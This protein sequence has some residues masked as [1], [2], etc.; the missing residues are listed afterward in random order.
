MYLKGVSLMRRPSVKKWLARRH[1]FLKKPL[2]ILVVLSAVLSLTAVLFAYLTKVTLDSVAARDG[3]RFVMGAV[4]LV[5]VLLAQILFKSLH[6]YLSVY[7]RTRTDNVL[8]RRFYQGFL[9][10]RHQM[11]ADYHTGSLMNTLE[12]DVGTV[13]EGLVMLLPEAVFLTL[14]F[15]LAFA[16]LF[17]L[18]WIFGA[19]MFGIGGLFLLASFLIRQA[20]KRRHNR[21]KDVEGARRGY[22]QETLAHS[23][24]IKAF[25]AE[26]YSTDR[27]D[28]HQSEFLKATMRKHR[29]TLFAAMALNAFFAGGY[30][31]AIIYGGLRM[32]EGVLMVGSLVAIIQLIQYMQS[33]FSGLSSLMPK[34][35]SL[36]ASAE[37]LM[38]MENLPK[39]PD[40]EDEPEGPFRGVEC[41]N[42]HFKYEDAWIIAGLDLVI[43]AGSFI[44]IEGASGIGKTTF[45]KLLLGLLEPDAGS[46]RFNVG[47]RPHPAGMNTRPLLTYVPQTPM[48]L[49]GTIRENIVFNTEGVTPES[50]REA[51]RIAAIDETI[52]ALEEGYDTR[53]NEHGK[54]FSEGQLQRLAIA[55]AVLRDAPVLLLDEVTSALDASSEAL[56]LDNLKQL[57]D[58][59]CLVISHRPIPESLIDRRLKL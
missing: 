26:R 12:S 19:L 45:F 44:H 17:Y 36:L 50:V 3:T 30:A 20:I 6:R 31:F 7:Y 58:K 5:S 43:P 46:I 29:L 38:T 35:Y 25:E 14:R 18:D 9:S 42:V 22:L 51:A 32:H 8:K 40:V 11:L 41:E 10:T 27:L 48:I 16:L 13:S 34:Y 53:L 1:G 39:D 33:P 57:T 55:R 56:V 49:S 15:V 59:T 2:I 24:L 23:T 28:A 37:R 54:G 47:D 52:E 21:L 4:L